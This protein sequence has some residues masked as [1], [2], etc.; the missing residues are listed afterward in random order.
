[1]KKICF[2]LDGVICVT[3]NGN[4]KTSKPKK[5]VINLINKLYDK[6]YIL[7]FTARYMGRSK[8]SIRLAKKRGFK[9]TLR[10][11]Q[12]WNLKFHELKF[13]KP[14]YDLIIDDKSLGFK[15]NWHKNLKKIN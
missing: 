2:D 11:L 15:K 9:F 13:G 4:Y 14:S 6:Y 7:I 10:Q 3:K 1:M 12:K 5:E 8:E